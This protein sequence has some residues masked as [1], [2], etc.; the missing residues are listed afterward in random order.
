MNLI[1][2]TCKRK[3]S[4]DV[5]VHFKVMYLEY[6][7]TDVFWLPQFACFLNGALWSIS[8]AKHEFDNRHTSLYKIT[9]GGKYVHIC[10]LETSG[11]N[12]Y[13]DKQISHSAF[14][15]DHCTFRWLKT[16]WMAG[17]EVSVLSS[18]DQCSLIRLL[19]PLP[20]GSIP[21]L[22]RLCIYSAHLQYILSRGLQP[23]ICIDHA[24]I[25]HSWS[26]IGTYDA[27]TFSLQNNNPHVLY[28]TFT[29]P[30]EG[31]V[32]PAATCSPVPP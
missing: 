14:T 32:P 25:L 13:M 26:T 30:G 16:S 2:T 3:T 10:R 11:Q 8:S 22:E 27:F 31:R 15:D 9:V 24:S 23:N 18:L 28:P 19:R 1:K 12:G 20:R 17:R 7:I 29:L 6:V 5:W 21:P 4:T